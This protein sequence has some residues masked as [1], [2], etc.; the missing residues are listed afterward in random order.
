MSQFTVEA[1]EAI[2]LE[3][4]LSAGLGA[5][6]VVEPPPRMVLPGADLRSR[7]GTAERLASQNAIFD[8]YK[9]LWHNHLPS[10]GRELSTFS[11]NTL[12]KLN[13]CIHLVF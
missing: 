9:Y 1:R 12:L 2:G 4:G 3:A 10:I 8:F 5:R 7:A 6:E 11:F 13:K